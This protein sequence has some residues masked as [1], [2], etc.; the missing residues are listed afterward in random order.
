MMPP[1]PGAALGGTLWIVQQ[2]CNH[3]TLI[4][5]G[6]QNCRLL[7]R[8]TSVAVVLRALGPA[9]AVW[10]RQATCCPPGQLTF[11]IRLS[12][13]PAALALPLR[14]LPAVDRGWMR[15]RRS[16]VAHNDLPA[17]LRTL[18]EVAE[19]MAH[20]HS[21][22]ILHCDL[23]GGWVGGRLLACL[24]AVSPPGLLTC[25][26]A[27]MLRCVAASLPCLGCC[28]RLPCTRR[29]CP[30]L[31]ST[32]LLCLLCLPSGN[33]V[34]LEAIDGD[35]AAAAAAAGDS[36]GF[37]ARVCDFGLAKVATGGQLT[38]STF[39]T[40]SHM[41]PGEQA[42]EG[43]SQ[44]AGLGPAECPLQ[45]AQLAQPGAVAAARGQHTARALQRQV[46]AACSRHLIT[47]CPSARSPPSL[48]PL[49]CRADG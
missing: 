2:M 42:R 3:G 20:L 29:P 49:R 27:C 22:N 33:N 7:V 13:L 34:L 25:V 37:R 17:M 36:R 41:A 40:C 21:Q 47:H 6:K 23:T 32:C 30:F 38:T 24:R 8:A 14:C 5:A 46:S 18:R 31:L 48:L 12:L 44:R 16:L 10:G 45:R 39:G 26:V 11:F 19:G 15:V 4:E 1:K 43:G 28:A 35:A 9:A